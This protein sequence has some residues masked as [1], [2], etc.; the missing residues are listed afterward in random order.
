MKLKLHQ[1]IAPLLALSAL[2]SGPASGA[3]LKTERFDR[4]PGWEGHNNLIVPKYV[5]M[6]K[7]DFGYSATHFAGQVAGEMGGVIQRSTTPA[8]YAAKIA[9]KTLDDRLTLNQAW[10]EAGIA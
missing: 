2:L 9:T 7:Q 5:P 3:D 1:S 6:V 8:S 4:D 10:Y